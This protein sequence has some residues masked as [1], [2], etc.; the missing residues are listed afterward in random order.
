MTQV[1][2]FIESR[3]AGL[4]PSGRARPSR[5]YRSREIPPLGSSWWAVGSKTKRSGPIPSQKWRCTIS[6]PSRRPL[7]CLVDQVGANG[8]G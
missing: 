3:P 5:T 8:H 1:P 4:R 2:G 7:R 6:S